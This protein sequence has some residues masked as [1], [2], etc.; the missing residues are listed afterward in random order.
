MKWLKQYYYLL[1]VL[2]YLPSLLNF[3][4]GDDWFHLRITQIQNASDF[5]KFFS[6]IPNDLTASFYRPLSTQVFFYIFQSIF[7]LRALPYYLLGMF[8]LGYTSHLIYK[9][10]DSKIAAFI[11][12][13]SVSNFTRVYFLSA[14]QELFL[15]IFSLLTILYFVKKPGMATLF[16]ILALLSKET[17]VVLPALIFLLHHKSVLK[18]LRPYIVIISLDLIYLYLRFFYFGLAG[19]DSYVWNFSPVKLANTLMWYVLWSFGAP[20][21]LVDYVGSGLR[22]VPKF[23]IDYS[24]WWK[25]IIYPLVGTILISLILG[26]KKLRQI[27][28]NIVKYKMFFLVSLLPVAFLPSHKFSLE[29]GLPMVGFVM[30]IAWLIPKKHTILSLC[31]LSL[32]VFLNLSMNLLTYYRHYSISRGVIS[33]NVY[34]FFLQNYTAKPQG[35]YFEF[36]NDSENHGEIWGQSKQI[37]QAL[38]GS[39]FFRVFYKDPSFKV[40][41]ED[42]ADEKPT[43]LTQTRLST[44]QF[45]TK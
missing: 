8:L 42:Y 4:S 24:A 41:Y 34:H 5:L 43:A 9:L 22:L 31:F 11:Y 44:K 15:V 35:K 17:A 38:S 25:I 29:L 26:I 30:I 32:Y 36:V 13:I 20:E 27:D 21:L 2:L 23:F 45:L 1:P 39:D 10:F 37:S 40:Y 16:F 3:F 14:Y 12:C 33:Q 28:L 7:G 18:N 19:G 6:F